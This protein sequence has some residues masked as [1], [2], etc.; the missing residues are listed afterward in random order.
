MDA[1]KIFYGID[2]VKK[3]KYPRRLIL[4]AVVFVL[5]FG[6]FKLGFYPEQWF[7]RATIF[8]EN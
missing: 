6:A 8:P 3:G 1:E 5:G 7:W 4:I 2:E